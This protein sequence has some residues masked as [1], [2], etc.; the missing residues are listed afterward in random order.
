VTFADGRVT[1]KHQVT[2]FMV[3]NHEGLMVTVGKQGD[4]GSEPG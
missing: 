2:G 3:F 1:L 4:V